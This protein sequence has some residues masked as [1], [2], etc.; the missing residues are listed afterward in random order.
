MF[1]ILVDT[2]VWMDMAKEP[3]QQLLLSVLEELI[4][5]QEV[6]ILLPE[7]VVDEFQRNRQRLI[8]DSRKSLS[9]VFKRV[10]EAVDKYG[11]SGSRK[12]VL[13]QLNDIDR[14]LPTLG[15]A[16][17]NSIS[18]IEKIFKTAETIETTEATKL[19]VFERA[20][21]VKAPFHAKRNC[22]GD[23]ILIETYADCVSGPHS[24]GHR[25]AFV[26]H[27]VNDFSDSQVDK[28]NPHPDIASLFSKRK[29]LYFT[30][31][32]E[33]LR[34]VRPDLVSELMAEPGEWEQPQRTLSEIL[35]A[36]HELFEKV[37][38]DRHQ[39]L[40][41]G[42]DSGE[43]RIVDKE[44]FPTPKGETRP[45]Q[46]DILKG[47]LAAARKVELRYGIEN[48]GPWTDFEWGMINGKLAALRWVLG[49][50]W[51]MLD[52]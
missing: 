25:F 47:A 35:A 8:D 32:G 30:N 18:R 31:I 9:S 29:S 3:Q 28:R 13:A 5:L 23:A 49:D 41:N 17:G 22:T 40:R 27:N 51:D 24:T 11:E 6:G 26:T 10:K 37:G 52:T 34:R 36:E 1:K 45:V 33:A 12:M 2:C 19:R 7:V 43:I 21:E 44:T 38:Y 4:K 42:V 39:S 46:K 50:D 20:L 14:R 15:D 16:V 48:L